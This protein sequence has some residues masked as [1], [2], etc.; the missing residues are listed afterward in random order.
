MV[1]QKESINK[2]KFMVVYFFKRVTVS[3]SSHLG[4][5]VCILKA[6]KEISATF[7]LQGNVFDLNFCFS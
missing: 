5:Y 1:V 4:S 7:N 6:E 2:P 3:D